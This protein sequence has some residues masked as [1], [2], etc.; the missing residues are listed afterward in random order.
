MHVT[1]SE[2]ASFINR[3]NGKHHW[4]DPFSLQTVVNYS[5]RVFVSC[6][7]KAMNTGYAF[8][9]YW[10][11]WKFPLGMMYAP[12]LATLKFENGHLGKFG[13]YHYIVSELEQ[14]H[15]SVNKEACRHIAT[16]L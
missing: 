9:W 11:F 1:L 7:S 6:S 12:I 5:L 14:K 8:Q 4:C 15:N 16:T 3:S 10:Q 13:N 2:C